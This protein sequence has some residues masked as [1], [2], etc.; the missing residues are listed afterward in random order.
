MP[1]TAGEIL[2]K[3]SAPAASAGNATA[4]ADP[5]ASLGKY[6]SSTQLTDNVNGNLFDD[7]T[8]AESAAG[9]TDYR[10]LFI[11]NSN[12]GGSTLTATKVWLQSEVAG[13]GAIAI[14]VDPT[15]ASAAGSSTQQALAPAND[16]TAPAGV[17][18]TS[19]TSEASA[20]VIGDLAP[21]QCR[22]FWLRRTVPASTAALAND[23]VTLRVKG[24]TV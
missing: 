7:V 6:M 5:N 19:P 3:L 17:T 15:A 14:G 9:L 11:H 1:V 2:V 8:G 22:A 10:C 16:V 24:D 18:F 12:A 23:G 21:G 20:I 13:G 4:Q